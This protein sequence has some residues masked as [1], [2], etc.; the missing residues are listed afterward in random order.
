[1]KKI[2]FPRLKVYIFG[3]LA[4]SLVSVLLLM[5]GNTPNLIQTEQNGFESNDGSPK[6]ALEFYPIII[7]GEAE[8]E[9]FVVSENLEGDGTESHPYLFQ[10]YEFSNYTTGNTTKVLAL[11]HIKSYVIVETF[12]V[13]D[14]EL[15]DLY[16]TLFYFENVTNLNFRSIVIENVHNIDYDGTANTELLTLYKVYNSTISDIT[17]E[18]CTG[19][20]ITGFYVDTCTNVDLIDISIETFGAINRSTGISIYDCGFIDV[21]N[22]IMTEIF[23][24]IDDPGTNS[25]F[26]GLRY[27]TL[28]SG[29]IENCEFSN[30]NNSEYVIYFDFLSCSSLIMKNNEFYQFYGYYVT[31]FLNDVSSSS[32]DGNF[33][34]ELC[35]EQELYA[36]YV[37]SSATLTLSNNIFENFY[38][39]YAMGIFFMD[40]SDSFIFKN[41]IQGNM[42]GIYARFALMDANSEYNQIYYNFIFNST[43]PSVYDNSGLNIWSK[44]MY[45]EPLD[46]V[47]LVGNYYCDHNFDGDGTLHYFMNTPKIIDGTPGGAS[48]EH[49]LHFFGLDFDNDGLLNYYELLYHFDIWDA[50]TDN[51]GTLDGDEVNWAPIS[52]EEENS[53]DTTDDSTDDT[54]DDTT[55]DVSDDDNT[56]PE[57]FFSDPNTILLTAVSGLM[58]ATLG[59][60]IFKKPRI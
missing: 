55:D 28:I 40:T 21:S 12:F 23:N 34:H 51:D 30:F 3:F 14:L 53:D 56:S 54:T 9:A 26:I 6:S 17:I 18:N 52:P 49:P 46:V 50:D 41:I 35:A 1:M 37:D 16:A 42:E 5:H 43:G 57:G 15:N 32:F 44:L 38:S 24:L 31:G 8:L 2:T 11:S 39:L 27:N 33:F 48:D 7:D 19:D 36:F 59:V 20:Y 45:Y 47:T 60:S 29:I 58:V 22:V 10:N 13:H 4:F 25:R